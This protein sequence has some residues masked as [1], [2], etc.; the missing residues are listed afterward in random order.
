MTELFRRILWS[1]PAFF[2]GATLLFALLTQI[3]SV[4]TS[5]TRPVF[6]NA[7]PQSAQRAAEQAL[8]ALL[9]GKS[10]NLAQLGGAAL[11]TILPRFPSLSVSDRRLVA[12]ELWPVAERMGLAHLSR[13]RAQTDLNAIEQE[14]DQKLLFWERYQ[15]E[16]ALDLRRPA[17]ARLVRRVA[18]HD[19]TLRNP[20]LLAVDSF[21]LPE[22]IEAL[23]RVSGPA[24]VKRCARLM[25]PLRHVTGQ[26]WFLRP[27]ASVPEARR[28][29]TE[30][31]YY[32]D[33]EG[34]KWTNL[35]RIQQLTARFAQTEFVA[36][37][38]RSVRQLVGLDDSPQ[39][40]RARALAKSSGGRYLAS[41]VGLLVLGPLVAATV[42]VFQ[43]GKRRSHGAPLAFRVGLSLVWIL[44]LLLLVPLAGPSSAA[45]ILLLGAAAATF[46]LHRELTDRLDWR[47]H[48]VLH[49]RP[50]LARI[51]ATARWLY[52][53]LP[54]MT[55]LAIVEGALL[56]ICVETAR[57]ET[58]L[59]SE[60]IAALRRGDLDLLMAVC[61]A[62][63]VATGAAQIIGDLFLGIARTR[64]GET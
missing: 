10:S 16:H 56:V 63:A 43:L 13:T 35:D 53:S 30:I 44:V 59:G 7:R 15:Q 17:V 1:L 4:E 21:A 40:T 36:W 47:A 22:L 12:H 3:P 46:T 18:A 20:D 32:W 61:L 24:D 28:L 54:T 27:D 41:L 64:Q 58:G 8:S 33:N 39:M 42:F 34:A 2:L 52:P 55:P 14:D 26:A 50:R 48:Q 9:A 57:S 11:P 37:V 60:L 25:K 6:Y 19:A 31:R 51:G 23:G 29:T 38:A 5:L 62:L 49:S 45:T